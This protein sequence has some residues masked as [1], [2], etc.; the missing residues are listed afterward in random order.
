MARDNMHSVETAAGRWVSFE[1]FPPRP[2]EDPE[3]VWRTVQ[4][5]ASLQPKFVSVTYGA[6]GTT[7][8]SSLA[9]V[10]RMVEETTL[11][12]VA[13]LTCIGQ[14]V[15]ELVKHVRELEAAGVEHVLALRGDPR[16]GPGQPWTPTPGGVD[17]ACE[18]VS[19]LRTVSD[20]TVGVAFFPE[21]HRDARTLDFDAGVMRRKQDAGATFAITD[22]VTRVSDY[23]ALLTRAARVGV[24]IP[25][26]PGIMPIQTI[27]SMRR[28]MELSGRPIP[29]DIE[30]RLLQRVDDPEAVREEGTRIAC[31]LARDLLDAGAPGIHV[32]TL[33]SA[34]AALRLT[35]TIRNS[36][37]TDGQP[38]ARGFAD[39][40]HREWRRA[41]HLT[42][43]GS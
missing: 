20:L 28:M 12:V 11:V 29:P 4:R 27:R 40:R 30:A 34:A 25:I 9:L 19:L 37:P 22:M 36:S 24:M 39:G 18:L 2:N 32:Y 17:Y 38:S 33:N 41:T 42:G 8:G 35:S 6:G 26:V 43:A 14:P 23:E 1:V 15:R 31:E 5:L 10:R 3:S 16:G 21:G 13:H 7:Q